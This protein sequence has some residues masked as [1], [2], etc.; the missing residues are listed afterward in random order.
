MGKTVAQWFAETG[1]QSSLDNLSKGGYDP[2]TNANPYDMRQAQASISPSGAVNTAINAAASGQT[3]IT[4]SGNALPN[5]SPIGA[6]MSDAS[7]GL[8]VT[9]QQA[10]YPIA[11][12][13][14]GRVRYSDGSIR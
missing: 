13:P 5:Y 7:T 10:P 6:N 1:G 8:P 4:Q 12:M 3:A 9:G 11:S 14:D 2:R